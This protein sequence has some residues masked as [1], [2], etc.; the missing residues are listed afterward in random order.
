MSKKQAFLHV[1]CKTLN[2]PLRMKFWGNGTSGFHC[3]EYFTG[4][5]ESKKGQK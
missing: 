2:E 4:K 3:F 5:R 1:F